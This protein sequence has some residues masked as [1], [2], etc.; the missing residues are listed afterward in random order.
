VRDIM[1]HTEDHDPDYADRGLQTGLR[2]AASVNHFRALPMSNEDPAYDE[3]EDQNYDTDQP[4]YVI[5]PVY[6]D[7]P[8]DALMLVHDLLESLIGQLYD[9]YGTQIRRA[10]RARRLENERLFNEPLYCP[11]QQSSLSDDEPF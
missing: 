9:I 3:D 8:D 6:P 10:W 5:L 4:S 2:S 7:L 11:D 1:H